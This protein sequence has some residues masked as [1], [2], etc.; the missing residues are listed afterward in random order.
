MPNCKNCNE[1]FPCRIVISGKVRNLCTRKYCLNCSPFG[2]HNTR[3]FDKQ[4]LINENVICKCS[5]CK[6]E[7]CYNRDKGHRRELCNSCS[8]I[9]SQRNKKQKAIAFYGGCCKKCGYNKCVDALEFHHRENKEESPSY[10]IGRW[11][12]EKVKLELDKCD[13]LCSNCHKEEHY[14][15]RQENYKSRKLSIP[16]Q[17]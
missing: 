17:I 11:S 12:W 7:Y 15:L 14:K 9:K 5:E 16:I 8:V 13:L 4:K 3:N 2:L 10:I 1:K 6:R